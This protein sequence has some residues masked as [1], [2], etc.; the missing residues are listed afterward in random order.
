MSGFGWG[1]GFRLEG[2][3]KVKLEVG[4]SRGRGFGGV[5]LTC[6][7]LFVVSLS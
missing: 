6:R 4:I 5:N 7:L 1:H 3:R 2:A